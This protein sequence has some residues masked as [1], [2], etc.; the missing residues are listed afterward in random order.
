MQDLT[1]L[2]ETGRHR[3]I[4]DKQVQAYLRA[5][6]ESIQGVLSTIELI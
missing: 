6:S 3:E 4:D 1:L 2:F 5:L